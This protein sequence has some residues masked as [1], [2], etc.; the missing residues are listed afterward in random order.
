MKLISFTKQK[1][2]ITHGTKFRCWGNTKCPEINRYFSCKVTNNNNNNK[3]KA[4]Q[5]KQLTN[6]LTHQLADQST[7]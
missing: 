1:L 5:A 7:D 4:K 6:Q 3:K 2:S